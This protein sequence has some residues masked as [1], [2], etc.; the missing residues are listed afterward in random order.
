MKIL[1]A[2]D[3]STSCCILEAALTK[4]G[5]DIVSVADGTEAWE[6]LQ[7]SD[8]PKLAILDWMMP[9]IEGVYICTLNTRSTN[10][11]TI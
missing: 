4:W 1:I 2:D 9:G 8:A 6:K 5:Y 11:I 3:D 10:H 7:E